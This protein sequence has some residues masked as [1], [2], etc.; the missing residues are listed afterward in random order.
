MTAPVNNT[1]Y[2]RLCGY[3]AIAAVADNLLPRLM[4]DNQLGRFWEHRGEDGLQREKQLII[5]FLC[6]STGGP[7]LYTGRDMVT[8]HRGMRISDSDW[9]L[10]MGHLNDTLD[11][12][13]LA[14]PEKNDVRAFIQTTKAEIVEV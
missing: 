8:S 12:F 10:F 4:G 6:S 7:V 9:P 11:H 14:D 13:E 3:D 2:S 1:L 5:N